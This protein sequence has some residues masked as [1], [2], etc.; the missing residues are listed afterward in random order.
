MRRCFCFVAIASTL[1]CHSPGQYGFSRAYS[2]LDEEQAAASKAREY[3][4]VMV[5]RSPDQWK[6]KPVSLFGVVKSRTAGPGGMA[7]LTLSLRRLEPRNLCDSD[8]ESTCRVTVADREHGIVHVLAKLSDE[9]DIGKLSVGAGSL[10]R[11]IGVIG[12]EVSSSEG[13]A[14]I[15]AEY[16]RHWPRNYYVTGADRTHM[17]R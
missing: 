17:R 4:P 16:Y 3:D 10:V 2:P 15:R 5:Q 11:V 7:D 1:A 9:D 8:D 14:V 12:D 6:G 13:S